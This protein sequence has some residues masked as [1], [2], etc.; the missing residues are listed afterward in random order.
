MRNGLLG[1]AL[2]LST[3]AHAEVVVLKV[4]GM[5]CVSCEAKVTKALDALDFLSSSRASTHGGKV[6]TQLTGA[7]DTGVITATL[8]DLG[9]TITGQDLLKE[10]PD[11]SVKSRARNWAET[12][13]LDAS[14]ISKGPLV[15]FG[16]HL[17][18][19][20]FTIIDFG[21]LWCSPCHT[22]E[23]EIKRYMADHKDVAVRAVVLEG[24]DPK[25]S[26]AHPVVK[27]HLSGAPGLPYFIV[28]SPAGKVIYRGIH[29]VRVMQKIDKRRK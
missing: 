22:A 19:D 18:K 23:K 8:K 7:L 20:K 15:D 2:A 5:T 28:Y 16:D 14:I 6:C 27:Q 1:A 24:N 3:T 12:A 9:Y 17:A 21:A 10:C 11:I 25:T 26:F 4:D 13:G 29:S